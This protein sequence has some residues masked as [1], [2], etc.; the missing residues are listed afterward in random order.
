MRKRLHRQLNRYLSSKESHKN[1]HRGKLVALNKVVSTYQRASYW[2]WKNR[3]K[4]GRARRAF[5]RIRRGVQ[6]AKD[7]YKKGRTAWR[8]GGRRAL[9]KIRRTYKRGVRRLGKTVGRGI[10]RRVERF[11]G[12]SLK[13]LLRGAEML[14]SKIANVKE[15]R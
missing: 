8:K 2:L 9:G 12:R 14:K 5:G 3:E 13:E 4:L 1:P 11:T 10:N 7:M 15:W 6:G